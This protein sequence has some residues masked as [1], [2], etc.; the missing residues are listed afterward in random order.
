MF[1]R[2]GAIALL[3]VVWCYRAA[4]RMIPTAPDQLVSLTITGTLD[5][6]LGASDGPEH[7]VHLDEG[8]VIDR[9]G[10]GIRRNGHSHERRP[11]RRETVS[12]ALSGAKRG[13]RKMHLSCPA[14]AKSS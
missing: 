7:V 1:L 5:F 8:M 6:R 10:K 11:L 9:G 13:V 2:A 4:A 12:G 14:R 3:L